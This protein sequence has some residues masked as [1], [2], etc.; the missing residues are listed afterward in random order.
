MIRL[1]HAM[2]IACG[3]TMEQPPSLLGYLGQRP[4]KW[5][6]D[7]LT[8]LDEPL[9][10]SEY[11]ISVWDFLSAIVSQRQQWFAIYLLTGKTARN[12]LLEKDGSSFC[13]CPWK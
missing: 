13:P 3:R 2:I 9:C 7:L 1:L 5:F 8:L 10:D 11:D 12:S 4:A 6:L